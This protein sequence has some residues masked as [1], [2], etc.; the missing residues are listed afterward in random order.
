MLE[1]RPRESWVL[2]VPSWVIFK[3]TNK[4]VAAHIYICICAG[5][6]WWCVV[7]G[8]EA[9]DKACVHVYQNLCASCLLAVKLCFSC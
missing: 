4:L 9:L 1:L 8:D 7:N 6:C 2:I 5:K 3:Q